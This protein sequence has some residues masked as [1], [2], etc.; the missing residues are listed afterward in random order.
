MKLFHRLFHRRRANKPT[1]VTVGGGSGESPES[2]LVIRGANFDLAGTYAEFA[3]LTEVYGQKDE[4]WKLISH[5]HGRY[6]DREIDTIEI[7]FPDGKRQSVFFDISESLGK[8][9]DMEVTKPSY[10]S[11]RDSSEEDPLP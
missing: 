11:P 10:A 8:L 4:Q 9:P 6:G 5:S 3:Y 1:G 2:P 7:E